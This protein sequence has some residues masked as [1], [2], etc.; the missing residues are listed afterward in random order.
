VAGVKGRS[1]GKRQGAGRPPHSIARQFLTGKKPKRGAKPEST[2]AAGSSPLPC[3][4]G[5]SPADA[6]VWAELAPLAHARGTL[7]A[8]H[9]PAFTIL[10]AQVAAERALRLSPL[11][12]WGPDHRGVIRLMELG[13]AR[14][15][16]Q[17]DGKPAVAPEQPKDAFA[18]F[19]GPVLAKGAQTA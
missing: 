12:A 17:P 11:A 19:D 7:I 2:P 1:G 5:L 6:L 14:F 8:E 4:A 18:E 10:C 13:M 9:A 15:R 16:I 3:P